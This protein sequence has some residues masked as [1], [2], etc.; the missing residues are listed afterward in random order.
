MTRPGP[1]TGL[2]TLNLT[3]FL[4]ALNDNILKFLIIYHIIQHQPAL[5][6]SSVTAT[7]GA[8]FV[9]PFLLLS[10]LAG[11]L[12]TR[13]SKSRL[14]GWIKLLEVVIT[15]LAVPAFWMGSPLLLYLVL[16]AMAIHSALFAPCKYGIIPELVEHHALTRAN[17]AI[18]AATFLAI[19]IGTAS[20]SLLVDFTQA[21]YPLAA[22]AGVLIALTGWQAA[23]KLPVTAAAAPK[24]QGHLSPRP[25]LDSL[26]AHRRVT[27]IRVSLIGFAW[28]MLVG[29]FAQ[30]NLIGYGIV[31]LGL[32]ESQSGYLFFAAAI[33][34]AIGSLAAARFARAD[35][36]FGLVIPGGVG[37]LFCLIALALMPARL[38][39]IV[40][41]LILFGVSAGLFSVPFQTGLQAYADP[42]RRAELLAAAS[43]VNWFAVLMA[44]GLLLLVAHTAGCTPAESFFVMGILHGVVLLLLAWR[45]PLLWHHAQQ[46]L[47]RRES[48]TAGS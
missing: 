29:A 43:M 25:M 41:F 39:L 44:S 31:Q 5:S 13:Y 30:M 34:I 32:R 40:L 12:A 38:E 22:S 2:G 19:I 16:T 26:R 1:D 28:F 35:Q 33:G 21:R 15:C 46:R 4:G 37:M 36:P 11:N 17:G 42:P 6:P 20:A 47:S 10:P 45:Y 24:L 7:A 23:R 8:V 9:L 27:P 18:E 3:Q 48:H 14:I